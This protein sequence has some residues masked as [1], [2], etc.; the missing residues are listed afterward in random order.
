M[1]ACSVTSEN[2]PS[3][4]LRYRMFLP[5]FNPGG[6]NVLGTAPAMELVSDHKAAAALLVR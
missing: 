6:P 4:L 1:P 2:V 3:P 5:P